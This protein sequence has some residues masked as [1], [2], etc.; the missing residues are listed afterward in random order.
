MRSLFIDTSSFFM[1]IAIIEN[2]KVIYSKNQEYKTGMAENI[3]PEI[4][5]AFNN[6]N[7]KVNEIDKIFVVSGPGSFTGIRVGVC[8][9]KIIA[10]AVGCD[11]IPLSSLEFLATTKVDSKYIIPM[12]DARRGNVFTAVYDSNLNS[13]EKDQLI[14]KDEFLSNKK[15]YEIVSYDFDFIKP[16]PDI[17]KIVLKHMSDKG[18]NVHALKPNYLKLTEAEENNGKRS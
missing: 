8:A 10:W 18:E 14:N 15:E 2:N 12:I 5:E 3:V 7:F 13:I 11:V 6:V 1:S 17:L 9:A 4:D 16:N